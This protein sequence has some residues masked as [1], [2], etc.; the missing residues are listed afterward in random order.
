MQV[1]D[2]R[3]DSQLVAARHP[4]VLIRSCLVARQH[5]LEA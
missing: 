2:I 1:G 5:L 3:L 4:A